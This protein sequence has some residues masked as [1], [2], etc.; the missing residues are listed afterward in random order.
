MDALPFETGPIDS[1]PTI[2]AWQAEAPQLVAHMLDRWQLE[3]SEAFVGGVSASVLRVVTA[4]GRPAVLKVGFPHREAIWEGVGLAALPVGLGPAVLDQ[5]PWTWALLLEAIEPGVALRDADVAAEDALQIGGGLHRRLVSAGSATGIPTLAE[6]WAIDLGVVRARLDTFG[7]RLDALGI[8]ELA[9]RAP[10]DLE[11]LAAE[12]TART[13]LHGDYNPGNVL[14]SASG[15][16]IIDPKP[17]R[18][19]PAYDLWPLISQVGSPFESEESLAR[20][21]RVAADAAGVDARRVAS[22]SFALAGINLTWNLES[23][24]SADEDA[25]R[26]RMWAQLVDF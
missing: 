23:G 6:A 11:R 2:D 22:W 25:A 17:M 7:D 18:G 15:W 9:T 16:R 26:L 1:Y 4:E 14:C 10:D 3:A 20:H 19:D 12:D 24:H 13:L 8:L 5:D 21:V